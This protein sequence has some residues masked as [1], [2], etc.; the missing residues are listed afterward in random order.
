M[1]DRRAVGLW[2]SAGRVAAACVLGAAVPLSGFN[3]LNNAGDKL[4]VDAHPVL[5]FLM[6]ASLV[7]AL[8]IGCAIAWRRVPR[9]SVPHSLVAGFGLLLLGACLSLLHSDDR[10]DSFAQIVTGLLAPLALFCG[11]RRAAVSRRVLALV[12]LLVSA[13]LLLRADIVFFARNGWPTGTTLLRVKNLYEPHDFHYY[14]LQ[15]PIPTGMFAV[16]ILTFAALWWA[17]EP[18]TRWRWA[19]IAVTGVALVTLY[20]L[21]IRIALLLGLVVVGY[22]LF[23]VRF[24]LSAAVGV[25]VCVLAA[26][27]F[28]AVSGPSVHQA[29]DLLNISGEARV[30]SVGFGFRTLAHHPLTGLGF[31]WASRSGARTPAHS[32]VVQGGLE[33]GVA[34]FVGVAVLTAW[35]AREGWRAVRRDA[36]SVLSSAAFAALGLYALYALVAG[37]VNAGVNSGL[38]SVWALTCA[39]LLVIGLEGRCVAETAGEQAARA[40][41]TCEA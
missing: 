4:H 30:H 5:A 8:A 27:V 38:V 15:N 1:A 41:L 18:S 37:G 6:P 14:G 21:Y 26:L 9:W 31:G 22:T 24:R 29:L 3:P 39:V 35:L 19:L 11:L 2:R 32:D 25:A 17:R 23:R 10:A 40:S 34:G 33:M 28:V 36:R 12:L 13:L 20:L 7:G 16:L